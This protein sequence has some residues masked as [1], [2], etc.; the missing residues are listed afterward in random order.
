M[1]NEFETIKKYNNKEVFYIS[2]SYSSK[3]IYCGGRNGI[4]IYS[5]DRYLDSLGVFESLNDYYSSYTAY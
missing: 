1:E 3:Y 2:V 4:S 5:Y